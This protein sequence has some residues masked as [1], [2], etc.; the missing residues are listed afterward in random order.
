MTSQIEKV[1]A[2]QTPESLHLEFK[3][4]SVLLDK[5]RDDVCKAV[6]AMA[7]SDGGRIIFGVAEDKASSTFALDGG[8]DDV[9]RVVEWL[10]NILSDNIS[11][12]IVGISIQHEVIDEKRYLFMDVPK[13]TNAP[14]QS[15]DKRFFK[16]SNN[17]SFPMEAYEIDDVRHRR[18]A[19]PPPIT[20]EVI[21]APNSLT[22]LV[23][24]NRSEFVCRGLSLLV[25]S[26]FSMVSFGNKTEGAISLSRVGVGQVVEYDL[27]SIHGIL[28][29]A[30][31]AVLTAEGSYLND[32]SNNR[33]QISDR[34]CLGELMDT[35]LPQNEVSEKLTNIAKELRA[36]RD[37]IGKFADTAQA[38]SATIGGAGI[39]ISPYSLAQMKA[40]VFEDA[41][42]DFRYNIHALSL[43][44]LAEVLETTTDVVSGLYRRF[45][46]GTSAGSV[47]DVLGKLPSDVSERARKRLNFKRFG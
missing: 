28:S 31:D 22:N 9:P 27:D 39:R 43:D 12:R 4:A 46:V 16:R 25:Q 33:F 44:G 30:K 11:P 5:K 45:R 1:I 17:R 19:G 34:I 38:I 18:L 6:S 40:T 3:R 37:E 2:D 10:D 41:F 14:H 29:A 32:A 7:N 8:V 13:S 42:G 20:I 36:V 47:E 15:A 24:R 35:S 21:I 23:I 26:N